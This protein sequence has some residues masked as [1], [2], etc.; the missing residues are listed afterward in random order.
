METQS[1]HILIWHFESPEEDLFYITYFTK[2][3]GHQFELSLR[4][5]FLIIPIDVNTIVALISIENSSQI[6]ILCD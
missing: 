2:H 3:H 1:Y 4:P 5:Y 6:I